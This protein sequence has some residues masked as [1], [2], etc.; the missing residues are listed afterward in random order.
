MFYTFK[1]KPLSKLWS[2]TAITLLL[3]NLAFAGG[4][5][6]MTTI[7]Q[8]MQVEGQTIDEEST[9]LTIT[10][11]DVDT[12]RM[13]FGDPSNYLIVR[14]GKAYTIIQEDGETQVM[15]MAGMSAMVQAMGTK[16]KKNENPFGSIDSVKATNTSDTVAGIKGKTY[17]ISWT[18]ADGNQ[19]SG[20]AV[21][22]DDSLVVEMTQ[23]YLNSMSS[24]VGAEYTQSF[25]DA[26]PKDGRGL[27][28]M[29]DQFY[30]ESI[31]KTDPPASTFELP[32]KPIN[33]QDLFSGLEK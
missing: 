17:Q 21:L 26:L 22:T 19:K 4:K 20:D 30:V 33:L 25:L 27:L 29:G 32:G 16:D 2:L 28:Q 9:T 5:A 24:I 7:A 23:A 14:D 1:L 6:T 8:P 18:E 13:D 11:Q 3:P 31:Q 12:V 15:D 10:W